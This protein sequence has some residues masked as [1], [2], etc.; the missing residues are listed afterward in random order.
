MT[1]RSF[2]LSLGCVPRLSA[3]RQRGEVTAD[4]LRQIRGEQAFSGPTSPPVPGTGAYLTPSK[5]RPASA[6]PLILPRLIIPP[7]VSVKRSLWVFRA[8]KLELMKD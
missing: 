7:S 5:N 2:L 8:P 6:G 1:T 4:Q 3:Q